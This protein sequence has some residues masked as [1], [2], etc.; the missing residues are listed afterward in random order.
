[1][2]NAVLAQLEG[3]S[4]TGEELDR[5][6]AFIR[7]E[8]DSALGLL[9]QRLAEAN[10]DGITINLLADDAELSPNEAAK[11]LKM[12]RPHLLKFMR[13][14]ELPF[15][16][17]GSHQRIKM[18]DLRIFMQARE[19]GAEILANALHGTRQTEPLVASENVLAELEDL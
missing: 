18:S 15:H 16:T 10:E 17:V 1:M 19:K 12:S 7:E 6:R 11:L 8:Q 5:L 2:A 3:N 4:L 14:G 9:L 13:D